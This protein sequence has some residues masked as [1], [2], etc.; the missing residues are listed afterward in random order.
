[1]IFELKSVHS[2]NYY[3]CCHLIINFEKV[4]QMANICLKN[5]IKLML[6]KSRQIADCKKQILH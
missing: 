6:Q 4:K 5:L 2:L 3:S 1:M